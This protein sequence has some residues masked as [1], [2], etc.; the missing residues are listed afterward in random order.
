MELAVAVRAKHI[1]LGDLA[2]DEI[3]TGTAMYQ[4]HHVFPF[5]FGITVVELKARGVRLTATYA[6]MFGFVLLDPL[7]VTLA[8]LN[9]HTVLPWFSGED[10]NPPLTGS[11]PAFLPLEDPRMRELNSVSLVL[12]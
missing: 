8:R 5:V 4:S 1:A 3:D 10:S 2:L 6:R 7:L 12:F 9:C 11:E